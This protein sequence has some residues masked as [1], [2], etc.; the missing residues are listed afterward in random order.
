MQTAQKAMKMNSYLEKEKRWQEFRQK[1]QILKDMVDP[2]YLLESLGFTITRE[3][4]KEL[5]GTCAIHG[6]DNTT[7]FRFN[8]TT[9]SWVCFT[10]HC[11]DMNGKDIIGLIKSSRSCTFSEAVEYLSSLV[12]QVDHPTYVELKQRREREV[13]KTNYLD[14]K[15]KS[16]WTDEKTLEQ[17]KPTRS[18]YFN[19]FGFSNK[20]L[21][22]FEIAGGYVDSHGFLRDIVPIRG[23]DGKL[24]ACSMRDIRLDAPDDDFKYI[25]TKDFSKDTVLY[26]LHNAKKYTEKLPLIVV[27]GFKGVWRL[28]DYGIHNVVACMGSELTP[29]QI[30]LLY[31]HA[32][33]GVVLFLDND[34]AGVTGTFK[35]YNELKNKM[36]ISFELITEV[37]EDG[38]GLDPS[39]LDKE[40][41]HEYLRGYI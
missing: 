21:D 33:R 6:G 32:V 31:R 36:N 4:P 34:K 18:T 24:M 40:T 26:N 8:K 27:E 25:L 22:H 13:F 11:H 38:K 28:Y 29:G 23:E 15:S 20:T 1:V 41:V 17:F 39:D 7:A 14:K 12:G 9:R 2:R 30:H 19:E 37:D 5:R 35:I 16:R 10:H 3:T